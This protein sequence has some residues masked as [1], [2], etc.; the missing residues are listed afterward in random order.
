MIGRFGTG[1]AGRVDS[2]ARIAKADVC[3]EE[4]MEKI[5]SQDNFRSRRNGIKASMFAIN[6]VN[7]PRYCQCQRIAPLFNELLKVL[8]L[9]YTI[10]LWPKKKYPR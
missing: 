9:S 3:D 1:D 5:I 7:P 4:A 8:C 6:K 10:R 2:S